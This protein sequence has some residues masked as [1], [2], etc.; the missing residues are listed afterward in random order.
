MVEC[1][2]LENRWARKG[3]VSS[4]LTSSDFAE[5]KLSNSHGG[6]TQLFR[7]RASVSP[8]GGRYELSRRLLHVLCLRNSWRGNHARFAASMGP[9]GALGS[10]LRTCLSRNLRPVV[11]LGTPGH[12]SMRLGVDAASREGSLGR[13][14]HS[15][16]SKL[17]LHTQRASYSVSMTPTGRYTW[18]APISMNRAV[19]IQTAPVSTRTSL[20][21]G[22]GPAEQIGAVRAPAGVHVATATAQPETRPTEQRESPPRR[23][24]AREQAASRRTKPP[25]PATVAGM[26]AAKAARQ[27][28]M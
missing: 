12:R 16:V 9:R 8:V 19:A 4:N 25:T 18:H 26:P 13:Q 6:R 22:S 1:A 20:V 24:S 21:Q 11:L 14:W 10:L 3:P 15:S 17:L 28:S 23:D 2:G 5:G 27:T 7:A